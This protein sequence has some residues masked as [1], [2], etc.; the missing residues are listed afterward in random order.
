MYAEMLGDK[1]DE[2][3]SNVF[4]INTGWTGGGYGVGSRINLTYTR[5]MVHAALEGEL[6]TIETKKDPIFVL[7]IPIHVPGVPDRSLLPRNT[8][9]DP[10]KYDEEAISL[11]IG[12]ATCRQK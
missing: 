3:N 12:R 4:L 11:E 1:I 9:S 6:N 10:S 8:W 5:A 2:F 7:E